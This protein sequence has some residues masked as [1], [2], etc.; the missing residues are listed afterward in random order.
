MI[1]EIDPEERDCLI[2]AIE[3]CALPVKNV[4]WDIKKKLLEDK[5]NGKI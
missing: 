1:L 4:L 3:W 2:Q 5:N